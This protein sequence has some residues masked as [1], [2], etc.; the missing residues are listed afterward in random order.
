[1]SIRIC[2]YGPEREVATAADVETILAERAANGMNMWWVSL[3]A[4]YPCLSI[5]ANGDLACVHYHPHDRHA[6][7]QAQGPAPGLDAGGQ[8]M[9]SIS[10]PHE[11][12]WM[13]NPS[14]VAFSV[15]IRAV[16]DFLNDQKMS[17]SIEWLEL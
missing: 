3:D 1:M 6:G 16:Q 17:S 5:L 10:G 2:D 7:F 14:V 11:E 12:I 9:F 8:T 15:A 4:M 13:P